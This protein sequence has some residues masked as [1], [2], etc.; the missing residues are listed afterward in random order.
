MK[1]LNR[2]VIWASFMALGL[3]ACGGGGGG[4]DTAPVTSSSSSVG[5]LTGF[6]SVFVNGVEYETDNASISVDG[7]SATEDDL[8][9]GMVVNVTG[10]SNGA[11]GNAQSISTSDELEGWVDSNSIAA[12]QTTGTMMIMGQQVQVIDT[13][14]FES[15][16]A[17][18]TTFSDVV[19]GNI[20]EV[21]G[22]SDGNGN[23]VA[24]RIEVKAA[25]LATYLQSHPEGVEFKGTI[26]NHNPNQFLFDIGGMTVDYTNAD[27]SDMPNGAI[28]EGLF[29]E[30]K[31]SQGLDPNTGFL[32]ADKVELEDDDSSSDSSDDG[33]EF[34]IEGAITTDYDSNTGLFAIGMQQ[35]LVTNET[36]LEDLDL[37][38]LV[39][40]TIVE[41]EGTINANGELVAEEIEAEDG[42]DMAKF[43]IKSTI[44]TVTPDGV[45]ANSGTVTLSDA[46]STVIHLTNDTIMEDD[47][48]GNGSVMPVHNFNISHLAP[49]DYVEIKY[50]VDSQSGNN[51]AIKL[52]RDDNS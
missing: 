35:V 51:I 30:V 19:A 3:G 31:S 4:G 16:V 38:D 13:T 50:Y 20:V 43:E 41:V 27:L 12:G 17:G 10:S 11:S 25:D 22:Y 14:V 40:G 39:S 7:K 26:T 24:T 8:E 37:S 1:K 48:D 49:G 18:I 33:D 45:S 6:G 47:Y 46:N 32:L 44:A 9:V 2:T 28:S 34:E 29:V 52:E 15:E 36:E 21:H 23:I 42:E 5:V